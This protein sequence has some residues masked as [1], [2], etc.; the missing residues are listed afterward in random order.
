M[1]SGC[2]QLTIND[3]VHSN[4]G[5]KITDFI[6]ESS[7][8]DATAFIVNA[9]YFHGAWEHKF[10]KNKTTKAQFF[11]AENEAMEIDF[12]RTKGKRA[13]AEDDEIQVLSLEYTD[14]A[15]AMNIFLPKK[16]F[17]LNELLTKIDGTRIQNLLSR[18]NKWFSISIKIPK[19]KLETDFNL[20]EALISM[21][22]TNLFSGNADLTGITESD[23]NLMVSG[24]SHKAIIE[25]S[26]C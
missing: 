7:L 25:V 3:F 6:R 9:I 4:T 13:Y 11:S 12:M 15:Y 1:K 2:W 24:A 23:Q 17:G 8:Q 22:I 19:M 14:P 10:P 18:L 26:G 16:R 5:G 20:K 21:G